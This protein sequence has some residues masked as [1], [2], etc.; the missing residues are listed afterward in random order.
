MR[1]AIVAPPYPLEEAPAPPLG[2]TYVA[3]AFESAGA[4]VRIF[5]YIVSRYTPEKLRQQLDAFRP[6]VL[7]ATSVTLNFPGAA[8]IVC[9]AKR[10]RPSLVTLM[11]G[12]HVSFSAER[13]LNDYPGIDL[14]VAGEGERTIAELMAA[15]FDP[16]KWDKIPGVVFRRDGRIIDAG[17][18]PFTED[19]DAL[20]LPARHLLPLSRYQA[21]GYSISIITSRGCPYSCIFCQGRRMVGNRVRLRKASLVVD[22]I[23]E[24]LSYGIDRINVADDLFVSSRGKVKEVCD[25]I[26]RRGLKFAWSAFARVNTVDL[27]T[28]QLMR[29]AGC[30]SISF[31]VETGNPEMLKLIRKGITLDQVRYAVSLCR[32]AGILAHTSFIVGLP[33]ETAETLRETGEFAA[34]LGSL[35]G[36]HFLA[37]FPGT[38]VR[39]EVG[40]YDLEILTDDWTRYDANSAIVRTSALS[41]EAMNRFVADFESTITAAWEQM[42]RGHQDRTNTPEIDM[43]VEG[44]FRMK[45]VY[46][47]LSEDLIE[48][49]GEISAAEFVG[50]AACLEE[51][52]C[53]RIEEATGAEAGLI[54]GAIRGFIEKGYIR[55]GIS[56][57][58]CRWYWTHNNRVDRLDAEPESIAVSVPAI[59]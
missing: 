15:G 58:K 19:L 14:I 30:D 12:P 41:P 26:L 45:L 8:A 18:R 54:H 4:E 53:R 29:K 36:Y 40:K 44:H 22:E 55:A 31:G 7:G 23:E 27:E 59:P 47:L 57:E 34:S 43:Q 48:K 42:V 50:S 20:P 5:D 52:L 9:E 33:G 17:P 24:I 11:G 56:G 16:E 46:R 38:T 1:V 39:E 49:W 6:D 2:V 13:T 21:L 35:Y 32:Q 51:E 28:L 3:A 25:E 37:P 10:H